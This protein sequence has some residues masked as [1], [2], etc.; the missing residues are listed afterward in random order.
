MKSGMIEYEI[1]GGIGSVTQALAWS[2][3]R[4]RAEPS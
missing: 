1:D 4:V 2:Q 3:L